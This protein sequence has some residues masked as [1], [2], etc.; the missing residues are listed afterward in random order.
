MQTPRE[1]LEPED[2]LQTLTRIR[3]LV[4]MN[5]DRVLALDPRRKAC[6]HDAT[7]ELSTGDATATTLETEAHVRI[8][9]SIPNQD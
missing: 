3:G 7:V 5:F 4:E 1:S 9:I 6:L 8:S 2:G